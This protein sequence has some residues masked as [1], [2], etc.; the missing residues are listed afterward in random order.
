MKDTTQ[1]LDALARL[2][3]DLQSIF[4]ERLASLSSYD[5]TGGAD[6][7]TGGTSA[8]PGERV[9]TL[10]VVASLNRQDLFG[11]AGFAKAWAKRGLATPLFMTPAELARSL[12]AFPLELGEMIASHNVVFGADPF[13]GLVVEA[14]DLRRACEIQA[15]SLLLHLREAYVEAAAHPKQVAR[16]IQSSSRPLRVLLAAMAR[17]EGID[18]ADADARTRHVSDSI[19]MSVSVVRQVIASD[20]QAGLSA[21]DAQEL[22]PAYVEAIER[23]VQFVDGWQA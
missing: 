21:I 7:L 2:V 8:A 22:Y 4:G 23:L 14:D 16:I 9:H 12:D 3:T 1:H 11:C 18:L 17:L 10:A 20:G 5:G 15:R 13:T 6:G 19:G